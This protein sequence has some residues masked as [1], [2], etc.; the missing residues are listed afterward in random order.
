MANK[1]KRDYFNELLTIVGENAELVD[2]INHE[3][4]LLDRKG[5][6]PR[7]PTANQLENADLKAQILMFLATTDEPMPIKAI[8]AGVPALVEL[9]NQRISRLL[10]DMAKDGKVVKTYVKKV[11][12]FDLAVEGEAEA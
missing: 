2:F 12:H 5:A 4:E 9:S 10:N 3:I 8:Q 11:A 1:T 7:K 6:T